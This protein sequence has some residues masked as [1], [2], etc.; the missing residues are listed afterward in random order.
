ME[1]SK[2]FGLQPTRKHGSGFTDGPLRKNNVGLFVG[3]SCVGDIN[4]SSR[5]IGGNNNNI[6][7]S[8]NGG[9]GSGTGGGDDRE[10]LRV[11]P[12]EDGQQ[13]IIMQE[14]KKKNCATVVGSSCVGGKNNNL[15]GGENSHG[16][17]GSGDGED[18]RVNPFEYSQQQRMMQEG[19]VARPVE[20]TVQRSFLDTL[21]RL[22]GLRG[23]AE[24]NFSHS[25]TSSASL[26]SSAV[27][28]LSKKRKGENHSS[29]T[30]KS[31]KNNEIYISESSDEGGDGHDR[32]E[33]DEEVEIV[34]NPLFLGN[35]TKPS[36]PPSKKKPR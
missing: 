21:D 36:V 35:L 30:Q 10:S 18:R 12:F 17:T 24:N 31:K 9:G 15:S 25:I 7:G 22:M 3:S 4:I 5:S 28:D 23:T 32:R 26:T 16:G 20:D 2:A 27:I 29:S 34:F 6:I 13:H 14:G 19:C 33:E 1:L 8:E 11:N